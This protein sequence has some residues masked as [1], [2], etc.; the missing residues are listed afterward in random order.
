MTRPSKQAIVAEL[1][2][3]HPRSHARELGID[4]GKNTPSPLYEWL[5]VS[6]LFSARISA[7]QA[8]KAAGAL[9]REGWRTPDRMAQSTWKQRVD[10]LNRNGYARYDESTARYIADATGHLRE[11]YGGDLRKLREKAGGDPREERKLLKAFKGIGDVGADIFCREAQ[12]AWDELYP[13]ADGKALKTAA[14]LG[15][16]DSADDLAA[17][18]DRSGLPTLLSALVRAGLARETHDLLE[19]A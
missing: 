1:L 11:A 17:L 9:F 16:G 8:Q 19:T 14:A 15:L 13:F 5:I 3:R 2:A 12:L 18:V 7:D 6:L 4:V 10:V